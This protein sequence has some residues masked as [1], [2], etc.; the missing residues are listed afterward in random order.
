VV[1]FL[2]RSIYRVTQP[3][4]SMKIWSRCWP[5][6]MAYLGGSEGWTVPSD[7]SRGSIF[8]RSY[9]L[10]FLSFIAQCNKR[11]IFIDLLDIFIWFS[12]IQMHWFFFFFFFFSSPRRWGGGGGGVNILLRHSLMELLLVILFFIAKSN[13]NFNIFIDLFDVFV[14]FLLIRY[15][16]PSH[17]HWPAKKNR[18]KARF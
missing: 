16:P 7:I 15:L 17:S 1:G 10:L 4:S 3:R 12:S 14:C 18:E 6:D 11:L 5:S 2:L 13:N 8:W 9:C